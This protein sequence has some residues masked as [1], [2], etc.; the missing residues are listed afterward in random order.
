MFKSLKGMPDL[1]PGESERWQAMENRLRT[2]L[3]SHGY[4]EIR[5]PI[6]EEAELFARS[7]GA[8]TDVVEKEMFSFQDK[9]G[10]SVTLRPEA[11]ASVIRA[12]LE[13][14]LGHGSALTKLYYLGPMFRHDRPQKGRF[15][16]FAQ[17]GVEAI[18]SAH[19][20]MDAEVVALSVDIC[21]W[22][23]LKE[24]QLELNSVGDEACRPGYR[25]ALHKYLK[26]HS[27]DLCENCLVRMEK[28]PLRVLD[29]K[30]ESCRNVVEKAP[31][32]TDHL[33]SP[34]KDHYEEVQEGLKHLGLHPKL[35]PRIV[36]GLD[37]YTRTA[38]EVSASGL[39]SQSA[40]AGGGRYDGLVEELGGP[41]TPAIGFAMGLER[42]LLAASD[43]HA[44][45]P[46]RRIEFLP[47]DAQSENAA[48]SFSQELR[49][50][51]IARN[52]SAAVEV[53]FGIT[54]L[55]SALRQA[56]KN[57]TGL[58]VLIGES[59][60]TKKVALLKNLVEHK[61]EEIPFSQLTQ[62]ILK[63]IHGKPA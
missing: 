49:R 35:N 15:R 18:G 24:I 25:K 43:L 20:R 3:H 53:A 38:F 40:V 21:T 11:T 22:F 44:P 41:P 36:R 48:A 54:S 29:C 14:H 12:Y 6:L 55:K 17:V 37:Y 59:E 52:L 61:Q 27:R 7:I 51:V 30:S 33:C 39:G 13:H 47:L 1:L 10:T 16:Q 31:R 60:R 46:S 5:T 26:E 32:I 63:R 8:D 4:R 50:E 56:D 34:C 58:A 42:L 57:R 45:V 28:N 2:I 9:G 23:G 19:P 62:E